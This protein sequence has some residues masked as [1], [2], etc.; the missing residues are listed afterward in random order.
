MKC[1]T[2]AIR[3]VAPALPVCMMFACRATL[4][5]TMAVP[6]IAEEMDLVLVCEQGGGDA[7]DGRV[8]PALQNRFSLALPMRA[9][10]HTS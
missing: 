2:K 10:I 5:G 7:V 9:K 1:R 8:T 4:E 6:N 3:R